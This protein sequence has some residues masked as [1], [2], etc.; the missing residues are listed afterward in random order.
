MVTCEVM[1]SDTKYYCDNCKAEMDDEDM[2]QIHVAV[3]FPYRDWQEDKDEFERDVAKYYPGPGYKP[4]YIGDA[5]WCEK[6]YK[7]KNLKAVIGHDAM[8]YFYN[9]GKKYI[10][11]EDKL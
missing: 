8:E 1:G 7:S 5:Q 11:D 6:C 2:Y 10:K 4:A 3:G 9:D